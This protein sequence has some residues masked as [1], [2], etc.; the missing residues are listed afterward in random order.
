MMN[1]DRIETAAQR[2][3]FALTKGTT[4]IRQQPCLEGEIETNRGRMC[5]Y[6]IRE[7]ARIQKPNGSVK[8][9]YGP[10]DGQFVRVLRQTIDANS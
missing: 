9:Y 4:E 8:Y 1:L 3:G 5:F 10:T 7:G 6:C 2:L